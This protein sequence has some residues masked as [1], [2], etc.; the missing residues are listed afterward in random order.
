MRH[1]EAVGPSPPALI[2][3]C[4][5]AAA[6]PETFAQTPARTAT[7]AELRV[8]RAGYGVA[9]ATLDAVCARRARARDVRGKEHKRKSAVGESK[10]DKR[11]RADR[12]APGKDGSAATALAHAKRTAHRHGGVAAPGH[13]H[14]HP[15]GARG[16]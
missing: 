8:V 6:T 12:S 4:R 1:R 10:N 2:N 11:A 7:P 9:G 5:H 13:P 16:R 15:R 3:I 14:Q